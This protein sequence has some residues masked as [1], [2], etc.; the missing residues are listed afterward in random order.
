MTRGWT[1]RR[2][3]IGT[4]GLGVYGLRDDGNF[5]T[6]AHV[7]SGACRLGDDRD[8]NLRDVWTRG[9]LNLGTMWT[10]C[11]GSGT[12]GIEEL[13]SPRRVDSV[14][15]TKSLSVVADRSQRP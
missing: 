13:W 7:D 6:L 9:R 12:C 15:P 10:L 8:F 2:V 3:G 4:C 5:E 1:Q 11:V 14:V